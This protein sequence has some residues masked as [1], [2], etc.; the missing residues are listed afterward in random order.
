[1][2]QREFLVNEAIVAY[3]LGKPYDSVVVATKSA[4]A[5]KMVFVHF[6]GWSRK[7]D[8]W[9]NG[10]D[11]AHKDDVQALEA[12][13]QR[14][15]QTSSVSSKIIAEREDIHGGKAKVEMAAAVDANSE[16]RSSGHGHGDSQE[17]EG[18]GD[19]EEEGGGRRSK[20][21]T[22]S[23]SSSKN[24]KRDRE[25]ENRACLELASEL[26][27]SRIVLAQ[28]DLADEGDV[29]RELLTRMAL[30]YALKRHLVDEWGLV[31]AEGKRLVTLPRA[32][33]VESILSEYMAA[34]T[35]LITKQQPVSGAASASPTASASDAA[36]AAAAAA[37][38]VSTA[39]ADAIRS[40]Q[41]LVDGLTVW[42]DR[43]LPVTLL[44]RQE[45]A[46]YELWEKCMN[47]EENSSSGS[48]DG[49]NLT[50]SQVYVFGSIVLPFY[51]VF[52]MPLS[53]SYPSVV[54]CLHYLIRH[55][56]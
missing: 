2:A 33:T 49:T 13:R 22:S 53:L 11:L 35:A 39:A 18:G 42:F 20:I 29:E 14:L 12:L 34:K 4:G 8:A 28:S 55:D 26:K 1:M 32:H 24:N 43:A 45:R 25:D 51:L 50:P 44:Y 27:R 10:S 15:G 38:A 7:Y 52:V 9:Y 3:D 48:G 36:T 54:A 40:Y 6:R 16:P 56:V 37:A 31:G 30:P 5:Q 21:E 46:Q 47:H 23:S 19:V 41:D 17:G